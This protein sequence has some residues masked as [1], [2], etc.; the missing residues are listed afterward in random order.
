MFD[1]FYSTKPEGTGLG[2]AIAQR[3]ALAHGGR[4]KITSTLGEGTRVE[5]ELPIA[6]AKQRNNMSDST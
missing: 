2:L 6:G 5:L 4:L 3:I 1:A